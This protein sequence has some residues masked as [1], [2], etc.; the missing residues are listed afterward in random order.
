MFDANAKL[1]AE[2]PQAR[3][4]AAVRELSVYTA[5]LYFTDTQLYIR[6]LVSG[7]EKPLESKY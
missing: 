7:L 1:P 3:R 2:A 4:P 6:I 5:P